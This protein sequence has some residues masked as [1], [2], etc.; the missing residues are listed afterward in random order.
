MV[1]RARPRHPSGRPIQ[2]P[3]ALAPLPL[4]RIP[5]EGPLTPRLRGPKP[6]EAKIISAVGFLRIVARE[7]E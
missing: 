1:P 2:Q 5:A 3:I 6:E 4:L 7:P